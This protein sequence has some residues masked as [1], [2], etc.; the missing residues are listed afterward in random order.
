[1]LL[2]YALISPD[3]N[4]H[5]I[6]MTVD[7]TCL[8][9]PSYVKKSKGL[10]KQQLSDHNSIVIK[11]SLPRSENI[12]EKKNAVKRWKITEEGLSKFKEV[13][14]IG[15]AKNVPEVNDYDS[16]ETYMVNCMTECFLC[17]RCD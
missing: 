3:F 6:S 13:T 16:L 5:M 15:A 10:V 9:C 2:D 4:R 11:L 8:Y 12:A 7:E 17:D 1:M 14:D